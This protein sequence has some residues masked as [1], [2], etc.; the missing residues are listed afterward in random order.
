MTT[1][2]VLPE[3]VLFAPF[4]F[5][6]SR[7]PSSTEGD[8]DLLSSLQLLDPKVLPRAKLSVS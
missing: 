7:H 3:N 6:S 5:I 8:W 4:I 1:S 2:K